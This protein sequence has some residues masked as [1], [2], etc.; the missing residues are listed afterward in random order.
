V[1][2]AVALREVSD[3]AATVRSRVTRSWSDVSGIHREPRIFAQWLAVS[4]RAQVSAVVVLLTLVFLAPPVTDALLDVVI[5]DGGFG[6]KLSG[7]FGTSRAEAQRASAA[8]T[9][10]VIG[11]IL[12]IAAVAVSL[13]WEVPESVRGALVRRR[14][15]GSG[16]RGAVAGR[17]LLG[18]RIGRGASGVVYRGEDATLGRPVALK[19]LAVTDAD[20]E[21][22]ERF[23]REAR[24]LAQLNHPGIVQVY[25]L[26]DH[27]GRMWIAM[28]LVEGGDLAG[29]LDGRMG[30]SNATS[31][32]DTMTEAETV[33]I[34]L[35]V[36]DAAAFAHE[37]GVVHRDLKPQNVMLAENGAP[38]L[39]DFGL[40]KI[41]G[42]STRTMEGAV[43]GSPCYMSPE[44]AEGQP[45]DQRSDIY[46]LGV[47]LYHMLAG[48]PP[49]EGEIASVL[50]QHLRRPPKPLRDAGADVS[51][52]LEGIVMEMLKKAP[53]ERPSSMRDVHA[54]LER[55]REGAATV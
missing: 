26:A 37:R 18:D 54:A 46:A 45:A 5:D 14:A 22:I 51:P 50:M 9:L 36:A 39:T 6:G 16:V 21:S 23:R 31:R 7:L 10:A 28:E 2:L 27:D 25:D 15:A 30:R 35:G 1:R 19:E 13:L 8:R 3:A 33:K 17:Y 47:V 52:E 29:R 40:A 43:L 32:A 49:F 12:G 41:R 44:Q 11:W 53:H 38:K 55:I 4:R 48:A 34:A 42:G 24:V 20:E